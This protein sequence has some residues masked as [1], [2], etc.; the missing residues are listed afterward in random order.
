[1]QILYQIHALQIFS[2]RSMTFLFLFGQILPQ[3]YLHTQHRRPPAPCRRSQL[4]AD[5]A[6]SQGPPS[7]SSS[8]RQTEPLLWS[9]RGGPGSF[10]RLSCSRSRSLGLGFFSR[11]LGPAEPEL[12]GD[13]G[14]GTFPQPGVSHVGKFLSSRCCPLGCWA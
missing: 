14:T 3:V 11:G 1:M 12:L 9:L 6:S 2:A 13:V 7:A 8:H 4:R 5:A 10:G